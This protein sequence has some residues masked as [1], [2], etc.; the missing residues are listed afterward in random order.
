MR[1]TRLDA[2]RVRFPLVKPYS[3]AYATTEVAENVFVR[4]ET[5]SPL[6][7]YGAASPD[8][9][10][11]GET[12]ETVLAGLLTRAEPIVRGRDPLDTAAI[13]R[14]L[15]AAFPRGPS[16][17]AAVDIALHDL[18]A[19][20][21]GLPLWQLLGG[22]RSSI[23][24]SVTVGILPEAETVEAAR[25]WVE[26][27]FTS[28]KLKG[29]LDVDSDIERVFKVRE[30]LGSDVELCFDANQGYDLNDALRF[31][32]RACQAAVRFLEQPTP[33]GDLEMLSQV[34]RAGLLRIMADESV[35]S[36]NDALTLATTSSVDYFNIKLMKHGG[37]SGA[38]RI[39]TIAECAGIPAMVGCMDESALSIAAGL[40]FALARP[41]VFQADLDGHLTLL[42]D[43]VLGQIRLSEGI[44]RGTNEPGLG[45][46]ACA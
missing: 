45:V 42:E 29:G 31:S 43:P 32:E 9:E 5:D 28:L 10:V 30:A 16:A 36:P 12:P 40:A 17:L 23:K 37:I 8:I 2:W 46:L 35:V 41:N 25:R 38:M 4:L 1:I 14:D 44:L 22:Y 34:K 27:G 20:I 19:R 7:G 24:T 39:D 33:K 15:A 21:A 11:T 18:K 26:R 3:I 13:V 6:A